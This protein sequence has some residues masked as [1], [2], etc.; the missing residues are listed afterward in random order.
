MT[1]EKI[2]PRL[3]KYLQLRMQMH[4]F[5]EQLEALLTEMDTLWYELT[6]ED[7]VWLDTHGTGDT[8]GRPSK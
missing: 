1:D 5:D 3:K 6:D 4:S 7:H 2:S 8:D